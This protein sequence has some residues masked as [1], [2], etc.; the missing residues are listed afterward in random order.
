MG[1]L[2]NEMSEL[3]QSEA[4]KGAEGDLTGMFPGQS[5]HM[6]SIQFD[7]LLLDMITRLNQA[8]LRLARELDERAASDTD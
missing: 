6:D 2:E 8:V 7:K 1:N 5:M 3:L 4:M